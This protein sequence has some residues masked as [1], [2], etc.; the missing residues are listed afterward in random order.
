M[1]LKKIGVTR[2]AIYRWENNKSYPDIDNLILLS[3]MYNVTL[4]A[5]IKRESKHERKNTY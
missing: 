4:D 2:Q 1:L 3:E 5:L